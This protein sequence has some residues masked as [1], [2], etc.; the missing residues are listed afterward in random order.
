MNFRTYRAGVVL[1]FLFCVGCATTVPTGIPAVKVGKKVTLFAT[2]DGTPPFNFRWE[3]D[4]QPI[5]NATGDRIVIDQVQLSDSGVYTC[6]VSNALGQTKV[7]HQ[8][9]VVAR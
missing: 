2:T 8:L 9:T 5:A 3:K 6:V 1:A 4:G 7:H